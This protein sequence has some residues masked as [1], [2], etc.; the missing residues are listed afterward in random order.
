MPLAEPACRIFTQ[1]KIAVRNESADQPAPD[2]VAQNKFAVIAFHDHGIAAAGRPKPARD[3]GTG[4]PASSSE[5]GVGDLSE[6]IPV[7]KD[8]AVG[9]SQHTFVQSGRS[10]ED[11]V[12]NEEFGDLRLT[13]WVYSDF[14]GF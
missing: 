1:P 13:S 4:R 3:G 11:F 9:R 6:N 7:K 12:Q 2:E 8:G 5:F 14:H 10:S